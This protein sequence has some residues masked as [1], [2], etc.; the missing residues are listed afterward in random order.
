VFR[1]D[2]AQATGLAQSVTV[3]N[4]TTNP[5]PVREQNIDSTV[6]GAIKVHEEGIAKTR[7][8]N[9]DADGNI[10]IHDQATANPFR[11]TLCNCPSSSD[12][13]HFKVPAGKRLVIQALTGS[14]NNN[15]GGDDRANSLIFQLEDTSVATPAVR[16]YQ[17]ASDGASFNFGS[18]TFWSFSEPTTIYVEDGVTVEGS[19]FGVAN[20]SWWITV[21][22]Y[23][24]S[25]P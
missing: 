2:I 6:G 17:F 7:E 22:G 10:K 24:V 5:V 12:V 16:L 19:I 18:T 9:L 8:Q 14:A 20:A 23:L 3:N 25:M 21:T 15:S 4:T 13:D 11:V 1:A